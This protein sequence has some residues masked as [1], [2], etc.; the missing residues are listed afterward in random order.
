[1]IRLPITQFSA[2]DII[3]IFREGLRQSRVVAG[4]KVV[5]YADSFTNPVY[6]AAFMA[7]ARDLGASAFTITQPLINVDASNS[8]GRANLQP[9]MIE[10]MKG[11][12]FV[13]DV[14]TGG[15]LYSN[16]HEA[17]L[18]TGTRILRVR[19]PEDILLRLMPSQEVKDR[20][21]RGVERYKL[22]KTVRLTSAGGTDLVMSRGA[23]LAGNQYG[24]ADEKGRWDHWGTGLVCTTVE[25]ETVEGVLVLSPGDVLF[26]FERYVTQPLKI[27]FEK[28]VAHRF[29]GGREALMLRSLIEDRGDEGARKL[30]HIGWGVEHRSTWDALST[31]NWDN[32]GG[33]ETRSFYGNVLVAIGENRD[34]G[35]QNASKLHI[36][37]SFRSTRLELDGEPIVDCC[38]FIDKSVA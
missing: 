22:A 9:L 32:A 23:R 1:M 31:R 20:A 25:E 28:G 5:V 10:V 30:S 2:A 34:L 17:I 29:E 8:V 14:S 13:V 18:A 37:M 16:D 12:D 27:Y 4:E 36:D 26:P 38:K 15:M 21:N 11:A 35:G 7:A 19:E 33:V 3:P 6:S 24:M